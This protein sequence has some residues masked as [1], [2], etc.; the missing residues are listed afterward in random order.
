MPRPARDERLEL[1]RDSV[2]VRAIQPTDIPELERFYANLSGESR[3]TRFLSETDGL[4][5]AQSVT[6]CATDHHHREGFVAV[7]NSGSSDQERIVGHLCVEP[8]GVNAA[9]VA[10]A[11]A[12]AFQRRGIGR[13]LLTAGAAWASRE[14]IGWF[15]ATM[16]GSN[17]A[18]HRLLFGL[19]LAVRQGPGAGGVTEISIDLASRRLASSPASA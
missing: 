2:R 5:Q 10:I 6:F 19:G 16:L 15:T 17:P 13:R 7:M 14:E 1:R 4:S 9:E 12:D 3:R 11:V 8:D 18:I